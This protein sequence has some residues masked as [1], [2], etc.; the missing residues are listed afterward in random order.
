MSSHSG[1]M[2]LNVQL[3]IARLSDFLIYT[4]FL[5]ITRK[6]YQCEVGFSFQTSF[7]FLYFV[8][9]MSYASHFSPFNHKVSDCLAF[10]ASP[11]C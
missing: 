5:R 11:I 2:F 10:I 6:Q 7:L 4:Y 1:A 9:F 3:V 8:L